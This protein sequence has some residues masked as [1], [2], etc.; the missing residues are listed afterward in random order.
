MGG[1]RSVSAHCRGSNSLESGGRPTVPRGCRLCG[2]YIYPD[3]QG[4]GACSWLDGQHNRAEAKSAFRL[5]CG[6]GASCC[7]A[8][9]L[10][11]LYLGLRGVLGDKP[12]RRFWVHR[13]LCHLLHNTK[14]CFVRSMRW[15]QWHNRVVRNQLLHNGFTTS[16]P[17]ILCLFR[18]TLSGAY[19]VVVPHLIRRSEG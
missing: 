15:V 3:E 17:M 4:R 2:D 10:F 12:F 8:S 18:E 9:G 7:A 16:V 14:S 19:N 5:L 11:R 1:N 6:G 13:C